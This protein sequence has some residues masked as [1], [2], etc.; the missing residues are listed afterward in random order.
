MRKVS[1][2]VL[3]L[4]ATDH[5]DTEQRADL[6]SLTSEML[7]HSKDYLEVL[8]SKK[9]GR[10]SD[11]QPQIAFLT[12]LLRGMRTLETTSAKEMSRFGRAL[13]TFSE[14][15][16]AALV[17]DLKMR[18]LMVS[19]SK[20]GQTLSKLE[21]ICQMP[22]DNSKLIGKIGRISPYFAD[23]DSA[24]RALQLAPL[25]NNRMILFHTRKGRESLNPDLDFTRHFLRPVLSKY[26]HTALLANQVHKGIYCW[27]INFN[28]HEYNQV[29]NSEM[30]T[31]DILELK[32]EKLLLPEHKLQL[33]KALGFDNANDLAGDVDRRLERS[34]HR[35][36]CAARE[37]G[38]K[39][40][41]WVRYRIPF[42]LA[43]DRK[44]MQEGSKLH[45]GQYMNCIHYVA[46]VLFQAVEEVNAELSRE[47]PFR[48]LRP[49]INPR[50]S[51]AGLLPNRLFNEL[52]K[53]SDVVQS[54][55]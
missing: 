39:N 35:L 40:S 52:K 22:L 23:A 27:H 7:L 26:L 38:L 41:T 46:S 17:S 47:L 9:Q 37:L 34:I 51:P 14:T 42:R 12:K 25:W 16:T 30:S 55:I 33:A 43:T 44:G 6:R 32:A 49:A 3:D 36:H 10:Q 15:P 13:Q 45:K 28:K 5:L 1:H 24:L 11:H 50:L 48:V 8:L 18:T 20:F 54:A 29:S 53:V 4:L 2:R 21:Q 31:S 19:S